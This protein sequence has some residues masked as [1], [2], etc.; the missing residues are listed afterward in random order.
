MLWKILPTAMQFGIDKVLSSGIR[1]TPEVYEAS[2]RA[3]NVSLNDTR[4]MERFPR[5]PKCARCRNHGVVSALKVRSHVYITLK[6][7]NLKCHTA[8]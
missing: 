5:T 7:K 2:D 6:T 8:S 3:E 4:K 1:H